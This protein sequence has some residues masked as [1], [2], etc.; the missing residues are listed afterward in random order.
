MKR[1]GAERGVVANVGYEER[2]PPNSFKSHEKESDS[3]FEGVRAACGALCLMPDRETKSGSWVNV[4][5][6]V[7]EG[8]PMHFCFFLR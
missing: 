8:L 1:R 3:T 5:D 2:A 7:P 6:C 4:G